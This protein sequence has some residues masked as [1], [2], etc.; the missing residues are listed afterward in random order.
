MSS[1]ASSNFIQTVINVIF[2]ITATAI[3]MLTVWQG[4]RVWKMWREHA[5]DQDNV[6]RDIELGLQSS[7]STVTSL[8]VPEREEVVASSASSAS[9][10]GEVADSA[11]V[12]VS[13]QRP[14]AHL[15][16]P[17]TVDAEASF[18]PALVQRARNDGNELPTGHNGN[19]RPVLTDMNHRELRPAAND[20]L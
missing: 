15:T 17:T 6:V 20:H 1:S 10:V 19:A 5:H 14:E 13:M 9:Q 4:H 8:D 12:H 2:G 18:S 3:G 11:H 7:Q 16:L